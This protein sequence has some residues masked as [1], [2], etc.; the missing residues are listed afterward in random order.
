[1]IAVSGSRASA[2]R[3]W[4]AEST[5]PPTKKL[6]HSRQDLRRTRRRRR[7]TVRSSK[8]AYRLG[9]RAGRAPARRGWG[10]V[11][12]RARIV[13]RAATIPRARM[14]TR[15][16]P[17]TPDGGSSGTNRADVID[18]EDQPNDPA[19]RNGHSLGSS[20]RAGCVHDVREAVE[21]S[22]DKKVRIRRRN[23]VSVVSASR[24]TTCAP[25]TGK[26]AARDRW[27]RA[28]RKPAYRAG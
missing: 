1:M 22:R 14:S 18:T 20:G 9:A 28:A 3:T 11:P 8:R 17:A 24:I 25:S 4:S 26:S 27:C 21:V 2:R 10:P 13:R 23:R 12:E 16:R 7:G 5:S 19:V 15:R 6:L